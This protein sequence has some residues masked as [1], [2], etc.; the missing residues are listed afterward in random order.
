MTM[1]EPLLLAGADDGLSSSGMQNTEFRKIR[2]GLGLT[3]AQL[4]DVL[5]YGSHMR[6]SDFE[7]ATNP[8]EIPLHVAMLMQAFESGYRPESWPE[9]R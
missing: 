1:R 6:I 8:R 3:Q 4:A 5:G 7:R 9:R 2:E